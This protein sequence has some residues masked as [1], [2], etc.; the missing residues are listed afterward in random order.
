MRV[1]FLLEHQWV[2]ESSVIVAYESLICPWCKKMD[3]KFIQSLLE[4]VQI[5]KNAG[6]PKNVCDLWDSWTV[7][8]QTRDSWTTSTKQKKNTAV[9]HSGN[10]TVLKIKHM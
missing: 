1:F 7:Q 9:D 4:R 5:H 2:F 3:L 6:K 8:E 10:N